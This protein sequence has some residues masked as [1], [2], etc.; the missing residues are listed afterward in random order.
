MR[1]AL[2]SIILI[3]FVLSA[4]A[5]KVVK[6]FEEASRMHEQ[7][8]YDSALYLYAAIYNKGIG[9]TELIAKSYYNI[10][11]IY[12]DRGNT[13]A[14][15]AVFEDL[16]TE[17]FN[18]MDH[19]GTGSGIMAEPYAIYKNRSC[20]ILA[21]LSI[22]AKDFKRALMYTEKADKEYPYRH[23]CGNEYAANDI[24]MAMMYA[25]CYA[26]LG[27]KDRAINTLFPHYMENGFA[28]NTELVDQLCKLLKEKYSKDE[29]SRQVELAIT[30]IYTK[31]VRKRNYTYKG[32]FVKMFNTELEITEYSSDIYFKKIKDQ[33]VVD[34]CRTYFKAS[35]FI[36]KLMEREK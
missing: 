26:G 14:A 16:L 12:L 34:L 18:E 31:E 32:Y 7:K 13:E 4:T 6:R 10:G 17:D 2:F 1:K 20:R 27:D 9:S 15:K 24:Y 21:H 8:N 23:F 5:Q 29:I 25:T 28:N 35:A 36:K 30:G 19:G 11:V 3:T 33:E 22:E